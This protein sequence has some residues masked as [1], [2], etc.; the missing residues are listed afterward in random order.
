VDL[1]GA[2]LVWF[3]RSIPRPKV[4]EPEAFASLMADD[5][6]LPPLENPPKISIVTPSYQQGNSLEWTMRSMLE[7]GCSNREYVVMDGGSNDGPS[8]NPN[9]DRLMQTAFAPP[10]TLAL[11][12]AKLQ[13]VRIMK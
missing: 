11:R 9:G 6:T 10:S 12:F 8:A 1:I 13:F 5:E 3:F 7:Q 4:P 2:P